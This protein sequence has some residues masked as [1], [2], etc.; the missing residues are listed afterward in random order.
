VLA[1]SAGVEAWRS[2]SGARRMDNANQP[3]RRRLPRIP[4]A[5]SPPV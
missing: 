2:E 4:T 1:A 3:D 5:M